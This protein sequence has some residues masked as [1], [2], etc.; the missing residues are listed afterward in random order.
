MVEWLLSG[1]HRVQTSR[2]SS[3][4]LQ[5]ILRSPTSLAFNLREKKGKEKQTRKLLSCHNKMAQLLS[6]ETAGGREWPAVEG[7]GLRWCSA[8]QTL[9]DAGRVTLQAEWLLLQLFQATGGKKACTFYLLE[10]LSFLP[11]LGKWYQLCKRQVVG[12]FFL[13][14]KCY[15]DPK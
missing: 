15:S 14:T 4:P 8:R 2:S 6:L 7:R 10:A 11:C 1:N 13:N 3:A 12:A 5:I 9:G